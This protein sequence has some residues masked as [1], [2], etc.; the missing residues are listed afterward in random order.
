M[1]QPSLNDLLQV[2]V[3]AAYAAGRRTLAYFNTRMA[4]ETKA[5][6]TP[7]T[8]AD[9]E[10]E[11]MIRRTILKHFPTH[12][13]LGEEGGICDGPWSKNRSNRPPK[14]SCS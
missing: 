14:G 1:T 13:I 9:R 4:V 8:C 11:E 12:C 10:A 6:N 7:V 2:A 3:D 5:D